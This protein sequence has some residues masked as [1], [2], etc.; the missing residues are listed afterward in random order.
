MRL[1]ST[2]L[3]EQL[4]PVPT[5][6][7]QPEITARRLRQLCP[8]RPTL[9]LVLGSGFG[10]VTERVTEARRIPYAKL[11]GFLAPKVPGHSG[12]VVLGRLG[13][14]PV[15][16]LSGRAHFYE[17]H[18]LAQV[19]FPMRVLA[20]LGVR[21]LLLTNA[22]GGINRKFRPGDFMRL[23]DHINFMGENPL[24]G[25]VAPGEKR[26]VDLTQVYEI[27]RAHV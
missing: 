4:R 23:T 12:E 27:G 9:A 16:V 1:E 21:D 25:P 19:T 8:L 11:P 15:I 14:T 18:S 5:I 20:A 17:G 3:A 13:G 7:A 2:V 6:H 26:F 10:R 24:R 22:A